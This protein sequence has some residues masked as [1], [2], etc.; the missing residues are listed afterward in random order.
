M[1]TVSIR[2]KRRKQRQR[3]AI[4][5]TVIIMVS[6]LALAYLLMS[7]YF[8]SHFYF[9]TEIN[10]L[11]VGGKTIEESEEKIAREVGDYLLTIH[12]RDGA[13][14]HVMGREIGCSYVPDG[15]LERALEE[16]N[17]F[18]W[19]PYLFKSHKIDIPTP[20]I[21]DQEA[22]QRTVAAL[23]GF[24]EE[25]IVHPVNA[26]LAQEGDGYVIVPEVLGNE[27]VLDKVAAYVGSA[28]N[29]GAGE[30]T[31][32][33][34]AY[35]N[36]S[37]YQDSPV[38]V[39]ALNRINSVL[40]G[41]IVYQIA[42]YDEQLTP[43]KI[44]DMLIV[45]EDFSLSLN[46]QKVA[47]FVQYLASKYNT[48]GDVRQ[49]AT[50]SGDT[51]SI[52]GGDY[53]WIINKEKEAVQLME[54]VLSGQKVTREPVYSQRAKV[55]GLEDI[56][57]TYIEVDYTKQHMWYYE[58][59]QLMLESDLVSGNISR[60]NGSPDGLFKIVYK[61]S[62]AVLKGEDY[63]SDVE[64][65]MP[66]AYNVGFHDASWRSQFG[67]EYYKTNGSHGCLNLP[68]DV[69]QQLYSM[70]EVDTPVIAYYREPV[71]LTAENCK[72]SNAY[73]YVEPPEET[74]DGQ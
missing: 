58:N 43:E 70:V 2:E 38:I 3:G 59:G 29:D 60:G 17:M 4:L 22:L 72:I 55:E 47:D 50:S 71:E 21:Y 7:F 57:N 27:M 73:S 33:D 9:H 46:E 18:A 63:E 44:S 62:P 30:V 37:I 19:L 45:A 52:G 24:S 42:D 16:Q 54:D 23:S 11:K 36:P 13:Q 34:D 61:K 51:I 32:P 56:G 49:F 41:G 6:L 8:K 68:G 12:G 69:A 39:D 5:V 64:Y 53:G 10:G 15:S 20:M 40:Q 74:P 28:V 31:L 65:F 48:Y 14:Y 67:G 35:V 1:R 26:T 66:F 25:N